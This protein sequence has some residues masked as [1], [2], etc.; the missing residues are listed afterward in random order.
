MICSYF[1]PSYTV[2]AKPHSSTSEHS[3]IFQFSMDLDIDLAPEWVWFTKDR[4]FHYHRVRG[5]TD[6]LIYN[7]WAYVLAHNEITILPDDRLEVQIRV[8]PCGT[9]V[10]SP[11]C[12]PQL[13][14]Q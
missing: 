13:Q 14:S 1:G 9:L 4:F 2:Q 10:T 3:L 11:N 7:K 6:K 12:F 8:L 5:F